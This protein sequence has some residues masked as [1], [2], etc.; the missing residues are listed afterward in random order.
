MSVLL[1][2]DDLLL[3]LP[4]GEREVGATDIAMRHRQWYVE[5]MA[6]PLWQNYIR[7]SDE[8]EGYYT[9]ADLGAW[10]IN[11]SK[12]EARAL[13]DEGRPVV[14][15]RHIKPKIDLLVG[16]E[17][18]NRMDLRALPQ[19]DEDEDDARI[20]TEYLKWTSDQKELN[21][22]TAAGFKDGL[23][24]GM[25]AV[26]VGIDWTEDPVNGDLFYELLRPGK[27]VIWDPWWK[28]HDFSLYS[29]R[30]VLRYEWVWIDDVVAMYP[31]KEPEIREALGRVL[32]PVGAET[33]TTDGGSDAYG[34]VLSHPIE[35]P[36]P[37][38]QFL[39]PVMQRVL[40]LT[41]YWREWR[42]KWIVADRATGTI[43]DFESGAEARAFA[44]TDPDHLHAVD[45]RTRVIRTATT[46]PATMTTLEAETDSPYTNDLAQYPIVAF[47]ADWTGDVIEG[48]VRSLKD[49]QRIRNKRASQSIELAAKYASMRP[50]AEEGALLNP[51]SLQTPG[52]QSV[53]QVRPGKMGAVG[54]F[55]PRGLAEATRVLQAI[56][57]DMEQTMLEIGPNQEML[58]QSGSPDSGIAIARRQMQG[59]VM[60][61]SYFDNHKR[62]R[63]LIAE[64]TARRIQ[65]TSTMERTVRLMGGDGRPLTIR[66]N[67]AEFRRNGYDKEALKRLR[68]EAAADPLKP[69]IL[70]D[71]ESLKFDLVVSEAPATPTARSALIEQL[72]KVVEKFPAIFPLVADVVFG[73]LPDLPDR[74]TV[75]QR[76]R[77]WMAAQGLQIDAALPAAPAPGA[78]P[79]SPASMPGA[80][81]GEV[82]TTVAPAP[83]MA[84]PGQ[85]PPGALGPLGAAA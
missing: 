69:R 42:T 61:L 44:A 2:D 76:I 29:A 12:T 18:Q 54:W 7:E 77:Q 11:G 47:L 33:R 25:Y 26:D 64:R 34:S 32:Q 81:P 56:S 30:Y 52:D 49:P 51:E 27:N 71:V 79:P 6:H 57:D 16:T 62:A 46:L 65:Q 22:L 85:V 4:R 20:M 78:L 66:L 40:M 82:G 23:I 83:P 70:R 10:S 8:D 24:R 50:M 53:L 45:K 73:L 17:R 21:E 59:M 48:L 60:S 35:T 1:P 28:K 72:L 58:G 5:A 80:A 19:G 31:D 84:A 37:L 63:K 38:G 15:L 13:V 67:P 39:D 36:Q 68:A 55:E 14:S 75:V 9:A 74:P 3:R 41:G 43:H